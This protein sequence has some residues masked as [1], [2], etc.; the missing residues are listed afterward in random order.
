TT[1]AVDLAT[2]E[3][4]GVLPDANVANDITISSSGT[5]DWTAL[6]NYPA[7]CGAN[8]AINAL[9][10]TVTCAGPF[11]TD[12]SITLQDAY[13]ATSGNTITATDARDISLTLANT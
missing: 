13:D 5:V 9:G 4:A 6:N 8:S 2:A 7:A 12:T 3:V 1:N 11:N 10:D